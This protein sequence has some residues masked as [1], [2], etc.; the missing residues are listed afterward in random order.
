MSKNSLVLLAFVVITF[1]SFT[2][3]MYL[4]ESARVSGTLLHAT[5]QHSRTKEREKERYST[6]T[7]A[8]QRLRSLKTV[9][10]AINFNNPFYNNIKVLRDLFDPVFGKVVFCGNKRHDDVI[11][12]NSPAGL[13]GYECVASVIR[14]YKNYTGYI[15]SND[16]VLFHW[17]TLKDFDLTKILLGDASLTLY[18]VNQLKS[19]PNWYYYKTQPTAKR[20]NSS[21]SEVLKISKTERGKHLG[22]P[23]YINRYHA[24]TN[25][26]LVC[27]HC[28]SDFFYIPREYAEI[29]ENLS[30]IQSRH[31]V[32][33]EVAVSNI[34]L[35]LVNSTNNECLN[36]RYKNNDLSLNVA[37]YHPFKLTKA[38]NSAYVRQLFIPHSELY[39]NYCE[40]K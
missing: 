33:L 17:W 40:M 20:C 25:N 7:Q 26:T 22:L 9:L 31:S 16:D 13:Y 18:G 4:K 32:F 39:M 15:H 36:G 5:P 23:M 8:C 11:L 1:F 6:T 27:N 28:W 38:V 14:L 12:I 24:N 30:R 3:Y 34:F 35:F 21:F 2:L 29:Y 37:F 19:N 10:L